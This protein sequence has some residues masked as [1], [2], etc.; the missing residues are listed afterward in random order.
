M[1]W[2]IAKRGGRDAPVIHETE[3][4]SRAWLKSASQME[5]TSPIQWAESR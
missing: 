1:P 4:Q 3:M 5:C 2:D